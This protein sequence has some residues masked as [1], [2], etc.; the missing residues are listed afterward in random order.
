MIITCTNCNK[1]FEV[2]SDLIPNEGRQL[3]CSSCNY[4]WFFKKKILTDTVK[5]DNSN[6]SISL[7]DTS[8]KKEDE[9]NIK[10]NLDNRDFLFEE[11]IKKEN[12]ENNINKP[13]NFRKKDIK[14][15]NGKKINIFNLIIVFIISFIALIILI[16]TFKKPISLVIP[17]VE[18]ILYNLYETFKDVILFFKDLL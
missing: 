5:K 17:N 3:Q 11:D 15:N 2:D 18:F 10:N 16:D 6:V 9:L 4:E 1:K 8:T 13:K 7:E 12:P 14:K